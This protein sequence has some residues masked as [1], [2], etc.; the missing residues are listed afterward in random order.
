MFKVVKEKTVFDDK[1]VVQKGRI[2][3][4][5]KKFSRLKLKREDLR[6]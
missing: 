1:L 4:K 2:S 3:Y 6:T 5:D